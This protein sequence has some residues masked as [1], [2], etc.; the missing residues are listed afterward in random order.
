MSRKYEAEIIANL[1]RAEES[2]NA[3]KDLVRQHYYDIA[4]SRAYYVVFYASTALLLSEEMVFSKHSAIISTIHKDFVKTGKL[5][6][7]LGKKL[8]WPFELRNVGD[9]G[10]TA[11]VPE[12][13]VEQATNAAEEFLRAIKR[14]LG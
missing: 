4:A 14:L 9:Y 2:L 13:D 12:Q 5:P 8:N 1:Q 6:K 10:V 7:Q 3:A 11:H